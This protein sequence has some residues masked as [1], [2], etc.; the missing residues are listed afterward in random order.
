[1]HEGFATAFNHVIVYPASVGM[2]APHTTRWTGS[3]CSAAAP[4]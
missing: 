1:M 3:R 2:P 4:G